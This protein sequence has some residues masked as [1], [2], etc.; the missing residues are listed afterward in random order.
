MGDD[1]SE[2]DSVALDFDERA[3]KLALFRAFREC[4]LQQSAEPVLLALNPDDVLN[5]LPSARARDVSG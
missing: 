3:A 2:L 4:F 5:L 1:A